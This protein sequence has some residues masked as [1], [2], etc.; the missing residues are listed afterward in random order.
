MMQETII[1]F[2]DEMRNICRWYASAW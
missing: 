2:D 1:I